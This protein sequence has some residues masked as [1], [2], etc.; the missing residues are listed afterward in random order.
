[1][2][3][4]TPGTP[5]PPSPKASLM[6]R[7]QSWRSSQL[8]ALVSPVNLSV[9]GLNPRWTDVLLSQMQHGERGQ[10]R[11]LQLLSVRPDVCERLHQR[12]PQGLGRG[13]Q[14]PARREGRSRPGGHLLLLRAAVQSW[15]VFKGSFH[16]I[17]SSSHCYTLTPSGFSLLQHNV[18]DGCSTWLEKKK[19]F[20]LFFSGN[21]RFLLNF[22]SI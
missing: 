9:T 4:I 5:P 1:M 11:G 12:R 22:F 15:L 14:A 8:L 18:N 6:Q 20:S 21:K 2:N 17:C 19:Y 16:S 13:L 3:P 10:R 7:A